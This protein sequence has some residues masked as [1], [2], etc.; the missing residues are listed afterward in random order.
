MQRGEIWFA[1]TPGGDRPVLVLTRD[2]VADRIQS[3]VVAALTRTRRNLVS[4]LALTA[5][6]DGIPT[7]CVVTFDNLHTL[8]RQAFRRRVATLPEGR[9][10]QACR[11][12]R[13]AFD[14]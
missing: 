2:P 6:A 13:D 12:M 1:A 3:V 10:A 8:P 7:D 5:A 9:M 11:V 4:E 14:C